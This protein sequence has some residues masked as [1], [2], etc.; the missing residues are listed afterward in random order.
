MSDLNPES[1]E[2]ALGSAFTEAAPAPKAAPKQAA[3]VAQEPAEDEGIQLPDEDPADLLDGEPEAAPTEAELEIDLGDE[4]IR[5]KDRV[6][7]LVQKGLKAGRGFEE[8]ARIRE[9]LAAQAQQSQMQAQFQQA[10][11]G[12]IAEL[13]ALDSRLKQF[14]NMDWQ[15]AY[16]T[17]P[18]NAL[19]IKEQ[20]DQLKEQRA[21]AIQNLNAKQQQ[22]GALFQQSTQRVL[23]AEAEALFA[24]VPTWRN[25]EK[26][27]AEQGEI[28][29]ML[30]SHYGFAPAEVGA[31]IDHR[32]L[33]VARDAAA[34]RKLLANKDSRVRQARE[35]PT[36]A[37]PGAASQPTNGR[38]DFNKVTGKLKE[39]GTKGNHRAQEQ[40][41]TK[42]FEKVFK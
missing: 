17:D 37:R 28:A 24:K 14:E 38:A 9:A 33:L 11:S 25:P 41:A 2:S 23:A 36:L 26:A 40:L 13:Q 30:T 31:L 10:V 5:G 21:A 42:L 27:K 18:F 39:L 3:P 32:M 35:A 29:G 22:F 34:Y 6:K 12:D 1:L 8:N 19:K 7:E 4:V 15:Q 20:R 16:D